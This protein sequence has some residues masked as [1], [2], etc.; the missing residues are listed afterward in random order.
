MPALMSESN[1]YKV[2]I[3]L[4]TWLNA[5][6][7]AG[8]QTSLAKS[9]QVYLNTLAVSIVNWYLNCLGWQTDLENSYSWNSE[10]RALLNIADI[11]LPNYGRVECIYLDEADSQQLSISQDISGDTIACVAVRLQ[12][13][14]QVAEILGF[15]TDIQSKT[16]LLRNLTPLDELP[17]YLASCGVAKGIAQSLVPLSSWFTEEVV[18]GWLNWQKFCQQYPAMAFRSNYIQTQ[19]SEIESET[20]TSAR[21]V[22]V[23]RLET[24]VRTYLVA[25][26]VELEERMDGTSDIVIK[27]CSADN[28]RLLPSGLVIDVLGERQ[29]LVLQICVQPDS[30]FVE[31]SLSGQ[32]EEVFSIRATFNDITLTESFRI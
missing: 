28:S 12:V 25:L 24:S 14:S 9:K 5:K 6:K 16:I 8:E 31:F 15:T 10:L 26:V 27:I 20:I 23:W 3:T 13:A 11:L 19:D 30:D 2:K 32:S 22:K 21:K 4:S 18:P 29:E 17:A 7:F 1:I